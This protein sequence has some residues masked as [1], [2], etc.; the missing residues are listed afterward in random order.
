MRVSGTNGCSW[1][2]I[3]S[4]TTPDCWTDSIQG[5]LQVGKRIYMS[6]SLFRKMALLWRNTKELLGVPGDILDTSA[7]QVRTSSTTSPH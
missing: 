5:S 1:L 4:A 6:I 3:L 2:G 7:D